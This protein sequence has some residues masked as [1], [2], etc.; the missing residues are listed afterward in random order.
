MSIAKMT[1]S[2]PRNQGKPKW[3]MR[4]RIILSTLLFC[5]AT[6]GYSLAFSEGDSRVAE[7]AVMSS[8]ALAATVIGSYV[9]GAVWDNKQLTKE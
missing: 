4:R 9:F 3:Q 6:V 1:K 5:A 2:C 7:T 8:F